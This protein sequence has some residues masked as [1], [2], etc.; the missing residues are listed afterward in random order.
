[1]R[2]KYI[3]PK[4]TVEAMAL[5]LL[6]DTSY[7]HVGG[8]GSFDAKEFSSNYYDDFYDEEEE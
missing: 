8:T 2:K 5:P 3:K 1:M 7:I 6:V 4:I